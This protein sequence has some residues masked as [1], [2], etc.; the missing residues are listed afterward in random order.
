MATIKDIAK[1]AGVSHATVSNVLN[2]KG[3][4]SAQKIKL[5]EDAA[6]SMGY[7]LNEAASS[8][9]SGKAHVIAIIM[10]DVDSAAYVDI[11]RAINQFAQKNGYSTM[12]RLTE[13]VPAME[14][15]AI[16]DVLSAR[17]RYL[18]TVTSL[19]NPEESYA[20]LRKFGTEIAFALR[21]APEGVLRMNFDMAKAARDIARRVLKEGVRCVG[22][23]TNMLMYPSEA[24]FNDV[25]TQLAGEKGVRV[26]HVQS[27]TSQNARQAFSV[28]DTKDM[29]DAI[30]TTSEEVA[31]AVL[32]AGEY[33]GFDAQRIYTLG[34]ARILQ[35]KEYHRYALNYR[36]LGTLLCEKLMEGETEA[37]L[38]ES[39]G[40][41]KPLCLPLYGREVLSILTKDNPFARALIKLSPRFEAE[42]GIRLSFTLR[43]SAEMNAIFAQA[44]EQRGFDVA[45]MDM[46]LLDRYAKGSFTP[47][48]DLD[49]D[50]EA[51]KQ[52][53][54]PDIY[55][56]FG[57]VDGISYALPLDPSC[58]ILFY[59]HDLIGNAH[60]QR[61]YYET[62][63]EEFT[64]FDTYERYLH[65]AQC[66]DRIARKTYVDKR[67][68]LLVGRASECIADMISWN[69]N[70]KWPT[71]SEQQMQQFIERRRAM[72]EVATIC[73]DGSW[74]S[75]VSSFSRGKSAMIIAYSN[76]A[77]PL[78]DDPLSRVSGRVEYAQVPGRKPLLGGGVIGVMR[79][80][81][82]K[83]EAATFL[84][85]VYSPGVRDHLALISGCSP[86]VSAYESDEILDVYPW[87]HYAQ[88]GLQQGIR[89]QIFTDIGRPKDQQKLE[90]CIARHCRSAINGE[91]T[92][93]ETIAQI[94]LTMRKMVDSTI[95]TAR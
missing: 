28:F 89:R 1:A 65:V 3:V 35:P 8:L 84:N 38:V 70:G 39:D 11:Y 80:S 10:P 74:N 53:L 64:S 12:L 17:A 31:R 21:G 27:I 36:K 33:L 46:A 47:L 57:E 16:H 66:Y 93:T 76:Y 75:C 25:F 22:L 48:A 72:E 4:V 13:N 24:T 44:E 29:P 40:F 18:V 20:E 58:T 30:I 50:M 73:E 49:V 23:M 37:T 55:K 83:K 87:L 86:C 7:R 61:M 78:A 63:K 91:L 95:R 9:R 68:I 90:Q 26:V 54:L 62:Y 45:R 42:T 59:R 41:A 6:R 79:S 34:P 69:E 56:E 71:L 43:S 32:S 5:V 51:L 14:R 81:A 94:E 67:G 60:F 15:S 2:Q 19:S 92:A 77:G 85:W 88:R 52:V 82:L